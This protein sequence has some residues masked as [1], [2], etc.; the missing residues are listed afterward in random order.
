MTNSAM[1]MA[2]L[3]DAIR[4]EFRSISAYLEGFPQL[5]LEIKGKEDAE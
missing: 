5:R 2:T 3:P 4:E 1:Q